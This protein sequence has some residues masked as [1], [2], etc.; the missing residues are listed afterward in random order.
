MC[1]GIPASGPPGVLGVVAGFS[2]FD[3]FLGGQPPS[4]HLKQ[5]RPRSCTCGPS[6]GGRAAQEAVNRTPF[7][8]QS[9]HFCSCTPPHSCTSFWSPTLCAYWRRIQGIRP[10]WPGV[11]P[12]HISLRPNCFCYVVLEEPASVNM[13]LRLDVPLCTSNPRLVG[14]SYL[15]QTPLCNLPLHSAYTPGTHRHLNFLAM[16]VLV[17]PLISPSAPALNTHTHTLPSLVCPASSSSCTRKYTLPSGSKPDCYV[18]ATW[19]VA[20]VCLTG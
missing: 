8:H 17:T 6:F 9:H 20:V 7:W 5:R 14:R 11:L 4:S 10:T 2:Y 1:G 19:R 15:L 16:A 18:E 13:K 12:V 3:F